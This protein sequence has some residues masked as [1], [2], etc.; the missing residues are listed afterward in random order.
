MLFSSNLP[1]PAAVIGFKPEFLD[2][3]RGIRVGNLEDHERITRILKLALEARYH[4][5]FVTERWGRGL[6]W[7]WIG[8]LP[9]ANREA[10]PISSGVSFGCAKFFLTV[11]TEEQLFKCGM[12]VERGYLQAPRA[13]RT[14]ELRSDWDWH[15]LRKALRPGSPL[16]R[17]LKRLV[18][19]EGFQ[20]FAGRWEGEAPS[21]SKNNFPS[22]T[23]LRRVVD[24]APPRH[25]AGFQVYYAMGEDEVQRSPGVDLV[26]SILA[27]FR[28]VTPAM[29]LC[30]QIELR[31]GQ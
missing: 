17:E 7:Q 30:M 28:E 31:E 16:E 11:D 14:C 13:Y 26:E 8:Y 10:K 15:R 6:Y 20:V 24:A 5:P 12:Q 4:Q 27:V 25:W 2:F 21:F 9:R 23:K 22:M 1:A 19:R 3:R 18:R 29:N